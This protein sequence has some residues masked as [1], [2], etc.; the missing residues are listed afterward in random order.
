MTIYQSK[1]HVEDSIQQVF[2]R[3]FVQF[4][5]LKNIKMH[6]SYDTEAL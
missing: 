4:D 2:Q 6:A 1:R 3:S 5:N